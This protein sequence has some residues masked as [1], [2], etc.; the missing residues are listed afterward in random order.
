MTIQNG[1]NFCTLKAK[2]LKTLMMYEKKLKMKLTEQLEL[3]KEFRRGPSICVYIPQMV[4]M[5]LIQ[6]ETALRSLTL[7][8]NAK[9]S[10]VLNLCLIDLPG[11]TKVPVGDQPDD[12]EQVVM[13]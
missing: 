12:I 7:F 11:Q 4:C 6:H 1:L 10:L 3:L 8:N 2:N 13:C 9:M 5:A